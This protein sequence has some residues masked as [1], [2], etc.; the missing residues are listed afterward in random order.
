MESLE[1]LVGCSIFFWKI[2]EKRTEHGI[3]PTILTTDKYL[4][5]Q[6]PQLHNPL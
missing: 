4:K 6:I 5:E 2:F 3:P 1:G